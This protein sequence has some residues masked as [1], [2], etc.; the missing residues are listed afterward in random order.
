MNDITVSIIVPIYNVEKYLRRCLD[1]VLKQTFKDFEVIMVDDLSTDESCSIAKEYADKYPNFKLFTNSA[2]GV[3]A[4]R[5]TGIDMASGKYIAFIDSDDFVDPKYLEILYDTAEK[6]GADISTCNYAKYYQEKDRYHKI[7]LRK[8][9]EKIYTNKKFVRMCLND[10]R[11]R[12]YLWNKLWKRSL[13][14]D[15]NIRFSDIYFEDIAICPQ[16]MHKANKVAVTDKCL[17]NYTQRSGSIMSSAMLAKIDGYTYTLALIRNFFENNGCYSDYKIIFN[18]FCI[19]VAFA[20]LYNV[21]AVH[22]SHK[23]FKNYGKNIAICFKGPLYY[24]KKHF[25]AVRQ[26]LPEMKFRLNDFSTPEQTAE[27]LGNEC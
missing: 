7:M 1:S 25:V 21:T 4:A 27:E 22:V 16:L 9:S 20:N 2:K 13:F 24:K 6:S 14:T 3:A 18:K 17:Y 19:C 8:P 10:I 26:G 23:C 15:N 5:N 12:S 11:V